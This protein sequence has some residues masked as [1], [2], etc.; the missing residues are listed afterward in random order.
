MI[1]PKITFRGWP[2]HFICGNRCVFRLNTLIEYQDIKIVVSTVGLMIKE[3]PN[4]SLEY[5]YEKIGVNRHYETM[6]FHAELTSFS[7]G[8]FWDANV[9]R[10]INFESEWCYQNIEDEQ[11]A[12][13]GHYKV[14]DEICY[15][16][17]NGHKFNE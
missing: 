6:A 10:E 12:Q 8:K 2:G 5:G 9:E 16:L 13:D 7:F 14:I 4:E 3:W 1:E 11:K 17:K 15:K